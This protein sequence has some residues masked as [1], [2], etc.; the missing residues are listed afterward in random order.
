MEEDVI[1][2]TGTLLFVD[3]NLSLDTPL[4]DVPIP[5]DFLE[6][7]CL[8]DNSFDASTNPIENSSKCTGLWATSQA[9]LK[10]A[11]F[12]ANGYAVKIDGADDRYNM[13]KIAALWASGRTVWWLQYN[14]NLTSVRYAKGYISAYADASPNQQNQTF[15]CTVTLTGE[16]GVAIP[17]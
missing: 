6:L 1:L 11:T 14:E 10:Q 4:E 17:T 7:I 5:G 12:G 3:E 16:I 8:T 15:T 9:G 13:D 2:G